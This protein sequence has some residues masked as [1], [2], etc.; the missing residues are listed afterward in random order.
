VA[1]DSITETLKTVTAGRH[2]PRGEARATVKTILEGS[3]DDAAIAGLLVALKMKGESPQEIAGFAEGMRDVQVSIRPRVDRVVDT[4]G[5]GGDG[6]GTFNISTASA[7]ITAGAGVPV[8]KH[9]NR[10]V[11]SRCG[12]ADVLSELGVDIGMSPERVKEC[13]ELVGIAFL[14][15]PTFHPAMKRVM[16]ARRS[17]GVPTIFN[18]LG[19]LTNPAGARTQVIGVSRKDLVDVIGE[20]LCELE[21][22]RAFVLHGADG[23]DEFSLVSDTFVCEVRAGKK[24]TYT[25]SPEDLGMTRCSQ[26]DLAGGDAGENASIIRD[27]LRG[28]GGARA[29][30]CIANAAFALVA[31]G[32]AEAP[33][34][35]VDLARHALKSGAAMQ[36]LEM[37][38]AFS[39]GEESTDVS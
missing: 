27:V 7:F 2:I 10:G 34:E 36:K 15:A 23:M 11:S 31:G 24:T 1:V 4:C 25:M 39:T 5:T 35:G 6:K 18:I 20:A 21:A 22:V 19:P 3:V 13:I 12:S 29:D 9:G 38:A 30:I 16:E 8:A 32:A 28:N 14:F 33:A 17:L 37:L 26:E